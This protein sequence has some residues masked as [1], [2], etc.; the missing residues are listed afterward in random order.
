LEQ[1]GRLY[2]VDV[3]ALV[4]YGQV[5]QSLENNAALFYWT[6][7]GMYIIPGNENSIQ[8]FVDTAVFDIKSKKMLFRV[9]GVNKL[10]KSSTAI[11]I[12]AILAEKSLEGFAL[13]VED[14]SKNLD[15]EFARF[16]TRVKE[17]KTARV[18]HRRGYKGGSINY[19]FLFLVLVVLKRKLTNSEKQIKSP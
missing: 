9:P 8:T 19:S 14:M 17:K 4:S 7:V 1:V 18:E 12:D 5:T 3:M 11:G 10:E 16:K 15:G 6:I 2:D 13:A